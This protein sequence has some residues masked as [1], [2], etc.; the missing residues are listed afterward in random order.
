MICSV[1]DTKLR[2]Q[3]YLR[4]LLVQLTE[5]RDIRVFSPFAEEERLLFPNA[6]FEVV[7]ALPHAQ[8]LAVFALSG[9][10]AHTLPPNT[11]LIVLRQ[12]ER[13]RSTWEVP[14]A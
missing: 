8:A 5:A 13:P 1:W 11:D 14:A 2:E 9:V 10:S 4:V 3:G 12:V 7:Q 6:T